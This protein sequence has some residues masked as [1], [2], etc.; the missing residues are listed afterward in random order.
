MTEAPKVEERAILDSDD[1]S[2]END[3]GK[4]KKKQKSESTKLAYQKSTPPGASTSTSRD[5]QHQIKDSRKDDQS[6]AAPDDLQKEHQENAA[7]AKKQEKKSTGNDAP[8]FNN[9]CYF[10]ATVRLSSTKIQSSSSPTKNDP[11]PIETQS[12]DVKSIS[13]QKQ[14]KQ[15]QEGPNHNNLSYFFALNSKVK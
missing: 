13:S 11:T 7:E 8:T 5:I 12:K 14:H 3:P 4:R 1:A 15:Q 6:I 10:Y 9:I 2:Q